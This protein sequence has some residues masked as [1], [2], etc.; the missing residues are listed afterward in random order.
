MKEK[1]DWLSSNDSRME[2]PP[3]IGKR[4]Q[5]TERKLELDRWRMSYSECVEKTWSDNV[6]I[7]MIIAQGIIGAYSLVICL[8]NICSLEWIPGFLKLVAGLTSFFASIFCVWGIFYV[9]L[10]IAALFQC[11]YPLPKFNFKQTFKFGNQNGS[12]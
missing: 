7:A 12:K 1:E 10:H 8:H 9:C 4:K 3:K 2:P 5:M 11:P 6:C